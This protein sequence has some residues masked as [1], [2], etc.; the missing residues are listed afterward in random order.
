ML[1][2]ID[3]LPQ[4]TSLALDPDSHTLYVSHLGGQLTVIDGPSSQVTARIALTGVG[5][6]SVATSRGL[7]YA[8]N[9]ATHELAVVEPVSQSVSTYVL[10]DEPAAVAA[11]ADSGSVYVLASKPNTILRIDPTNGTIVGQ[12]S[13]PDRS[14]RFGVATSA[15]NA[16]G[17]QGLRARMVLNPADESLYVTLPEAGSFSIVSNDM[18]P[19][20]DH[21]IPWVQ[22]PQSPVVASVIPGV[23]RPAA[24]PLPSQPAPIL[25]AQAPADD[26]ATTDDSTSASD[27]EEA[28]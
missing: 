19:P 10:P 8:I 13:L 7:A 25:Q 16:T 1:R 20:L 2:T 18:F 24:D 5:L 15:S 21:G 14:G 22:A 28:N 9:T 12:V 23:I 3:G 17:F 4:I 27:T 6:E 11:S 26:S